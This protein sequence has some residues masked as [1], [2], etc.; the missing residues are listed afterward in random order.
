[1]LL[2][3]IE[4]DFINIAYVKTETENQYNSYGENLGSDSELKVLTSVSGE[5]TKL[6]ATF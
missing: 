4:I 3:V 2:S 6:M 5:T 1:M